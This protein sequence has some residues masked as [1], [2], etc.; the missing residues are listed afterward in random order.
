MD[1]QAK[2]CFNQDTH[3][4]V[5]TAQNMFV[6]LV[7]KRLQV[8]LEDKSFLTLFNRLYGDFIQ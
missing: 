5:I 4:P 1:S 6:C 2:F 8:T 7:K 3:L